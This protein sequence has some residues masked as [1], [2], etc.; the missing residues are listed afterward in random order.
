MAGADAVVR[1]RIDLATKQE[2]TV[3]FR[4]MGITVSDAIRMMLVQAVAEKALPFE[5]RVPNAETVAA[6]Q[7]SRNGVVTR[8]AS[9][10]DLFTEDDEV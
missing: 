8:A 5:V 1:A 3:L 9:V 4:Q 6:L 10:D 2:A 7:D